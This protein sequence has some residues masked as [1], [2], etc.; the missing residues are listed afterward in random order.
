MITVTRRLAA[1]LATASLGAVM[2]LPVGAQ[3]HSMKMKHSMKT[4]HTMKHSKM[5]KG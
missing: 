2:A 4:H 5:K 3:A 1:V